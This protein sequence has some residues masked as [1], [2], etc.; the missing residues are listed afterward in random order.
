MRVRE[1]SCGLVTLLACSIAAAQGVKPVE[2]TRDQSIDAALTADA[3]RLEDGTPY[4]CFSINTRTGEEITVTLRSNAFDSG[5]HVS[6]GALCSASALKFDNDNFEPTTRDAQ[7]RFT[8]AGGRYLILARG[9]VTGSQG[10][11]TLRVTSGVT[12]TAQITSPR[13]SLQAETSGVAAPT[14]QTASIDAPMGEVKMDRRALMNQQVAAHRAKLAAE[15]ARLKAL[16]AEKE[17]EEQARRREER[18]AREQ[19]SERNAQMFGAIMN[20]LN[21]V[22]TEYSAEQS[23]IAERNARYAEVQAA[24]ERQRAAEAEAERAMLA[25]KQAEAAHDAVT[26]RAM[27]Q[28]EAQQRAAADAAAR[29]KAAAAARPTTV[30]SSAPQARPVFNSTQSANTSSSARDDSPS[31]LQ[32][33]PEAI[34]ACTKPDAAGRFECDTPTEVNQVGGPKVG[35]MGRSTPASFIG[36]ADSCP[37][38]R[39][40]PS[41]THIVWGCGVG[42]TGNSTTKD[43]SAGVDVKDRQTFYCYPLET[44]C[45]KT[46]P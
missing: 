14:Q 9:V 24:V 21:E 34:V 39:Q 38:P 15:E 18:L 42:A 3:T 23:R 17:M 6:R 30:A 40:L 41:T 7:V 16:E 4:G 25:A 13:T 10:A 1:I 11:Y 2:V 8:A 46:S 32:P 43:R 26:Q 36:T 37:S 19:R 20:G 12:E 45:R 31:R 29:D 33:T 22:A 27:Q 28:R 35:I 5:L 44:S